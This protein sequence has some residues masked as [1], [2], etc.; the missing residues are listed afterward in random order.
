MLGVVS[1]FADEPDGKELS[2]M[3]TIINSLKVTS[4]FQCRHT[5]MTITRPKQR[6]E[7]NPDEVIGHPVPRRALRFS[8][9]TA[10]PRNRR[11]CG[12]GNVKT[13]SV[14]WGEQSTINPGIGVNHG[15]KPHRNHR[16]W[17]VRRS[18][19]LSPPKGV[20]AARLN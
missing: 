11:E 9:S 19:R 20:L 16:H 15:G 8:G 1:L 3:I 13:S 14:E 17:N 6:N 10:E 5:Q 18:R 4:T 2:T 7:Q 12:E